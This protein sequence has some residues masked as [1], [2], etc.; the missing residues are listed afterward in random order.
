MK[1]A[2]LRYEQAA[3][4]ADDAIRRLRENAPSFPD[5]DL[6]AAEAAIAQLDLA[7]PG[8]RKGT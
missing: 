8:K 5:P 2:I 6:F 3:R 7:V 4:Q 1:A